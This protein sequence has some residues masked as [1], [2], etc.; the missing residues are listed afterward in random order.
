MAVVAVPEVVLKDRTKK[1]TSMN[2]NEHAMAAINVVADL[3]TPRCKQCGKTFERTRPWSQFC[4]PSCHA[5]YHTQRRT[6]A[7]D[8]WDRC[9]IAE[10]ERAE[11]DGGESNETA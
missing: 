11:L 9:P 6:L 3:C 8:H 4:S 2:P 7:I 10:Q 1:G 5:A